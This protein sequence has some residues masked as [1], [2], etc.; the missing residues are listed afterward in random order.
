MSSLKLTIVGT[1]PLY[2]NG[3]NPS[4]Y[5]N[6]I[7][8]AASRAENQG[9]TA[10]LVYSDH[11]QIEPWLAA[12]F[13]LSL[14]KKISP[15]VAVQPLYMH[16][17][18]VARMVSSLSLI[19]ERPIHLNF[20]SGGFPRDLETF[21]DEHTHD[22][23]YDRVT[24]YATIIRTLLSARTPCSFTGKYYQV[25]GLQLNLGRDLPAHYAPLFTMSGSS[26]AGLAA[27]R[28]LK[29]RAIQYLRPSHDYSGVT[30]SSEL[31][32]GARLGM[33][34]RETSEEAWSAARA[35]YPDSPIG[36]EIRDYFVSVSD[37]VWVKELGKDVQV[38]PGHPY[39]LGPYKNFQAACPFL[40]GSKQI[41]AFELA[42]YIEMGLRTF[43]IEDPET[44]EEAEQITSTFEL[45]E[46]IVTSHGSPMQIGN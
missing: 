43:L 2:E 12:N 20:V 28:R 3:T 42:G 16:P 24:E 6:K 32:Y 17:F 7:Q 27:A 36:Q 21:C 25:E 38:P 11:Q 13:L 30:L 1:C 23:R 10:L 33:V 22:E 9:W 14:T 26:P 31:Q 29:A 41:V 4:E 46:Q 18:S 39:W 15:L 8:T 44:D 35:R 37:S 40:V 34:V 5:L 45:A 19:Y